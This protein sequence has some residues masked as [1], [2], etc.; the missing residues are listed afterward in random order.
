MLLFSI[1]LFKKNL[2]RYSRVTFFCVK[3]SKEYWFTY[4][5]WNVYTYVFYIKVYF[6]ILS[7]VRTKNVNFYSH[8]FS[9]RKNVRSIANTYHFCSFM[10]IFHAG[11]NAV[12]SWKTRFWTAIQT[13]GNIRSVNPLYYIPK[14][15]GKVHGICSKM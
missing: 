13:A 7:R 4:E 2:C 11:K 3:Y 10:L 14:L 8:S 5:G 9:K 1:Q 6:K 15:N 12:N